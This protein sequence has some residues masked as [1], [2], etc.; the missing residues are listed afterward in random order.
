M[1]LVCL[2][3][4]TAQPLWM[5]CELSRPVVPCG[6]LLYCESFLNSHPYSVYVSGAAIVTAGTASMATAATAAMVVLNFMVLFLW[7]LGPAGTHQR[8]RVAAD[9]VVGVSSCVVTGFG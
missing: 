2:L 8:S 1:S 9:A 3:P 5:I 6:R 7:L 4:P